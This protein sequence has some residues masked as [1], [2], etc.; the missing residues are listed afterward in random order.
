MVISQ[1]I[2]GL[3]AHKEFIFFNTGIHFI[4][5][6]LIAT[7]LYPF[8]SKKLKEPMNYAWFVFFPALFGSIFPDLIFI[9][10]TFVQHRTLNGLF[11]SLSHG[12]EIYSAFHFGFPLLLVVPSMFFIVFIAH[13]LL[14]KRMCFINWKI[15]TF[16]ILIS[17]LS[18]LFHIYLDGV[19]F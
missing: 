6:V 11:E 8:L 4:V 19:G 14:R 13:R 7:S 12:G 18:A 10:S 17:L 9:I 15:F 16:M 5:G 3:N 1:V 2:T